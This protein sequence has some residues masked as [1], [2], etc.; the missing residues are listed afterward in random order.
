[1]YDRTYGG[2]DDAIAQTRRETFERDVGQNSWVDV[3]DLDSYAGRL[4]LTADS[5]L[6]E[7]ATGSGGPTLYLAGLAGCR[8]TGVEVN[9]LGVETARE[10]ARERGLADRVAFVAADATGPL[11]FAE[12][13][14]DG[15]LCIDAANHLPDRPAVLSEWRR[16]LRAG[17]RLLWT[18]PVVVAGPVTNAELAARSSIGTFLFVPPGTNERMIEAAGLRLLQADDET[19]RVAGV[20]GKWHDARA[21]HREALLE[22]ESPEQ[23]TGLQEFFAAVRDLSRERRLLRIAYLCER[24]D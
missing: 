22:H 12:E 13:S 16:L 7:V 3:D 2:R 19:A 18:D 9:P 4:A 15:V 6:L 17:G 20:A 24:L 21:R 10:A 23:W 1:M 8:I 14:F 5:H 11:P